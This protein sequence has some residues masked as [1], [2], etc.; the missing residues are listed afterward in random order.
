MGI[1]GFGISGFAREFQETSCFLLIK[2]LTGD[3]SPEND[4]NILVERWARNALRPFWNC[5]HVRLICVFASGQ[6]WV[7]PALYFAKTMY[8][9]LS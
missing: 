3:N 5:H 7:P 9:R 8:D 4:N 6:T 2:F 1:G